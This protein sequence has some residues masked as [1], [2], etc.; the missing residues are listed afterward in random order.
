MQ[1]FFIKGSSAIS[2]VTFV[3][4]F[5]M[6]VVWQGC[7]FRL[8]L[9]QCR[10]CL[11]KARTGTEGPWELN[12]C[13]C[14]AQAMKKCCYHILPVGSVQPALRQLKYSIHF[15]FLI[16]YK[17]FLFSLAVLNFEQLL[18]S[19][20]QVEGLFPRFWLVYLKAHT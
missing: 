5:I 16:F 6:M 12:D 14:S 15:L 13:N 17:Q 18:S 19:E 8:S 7:S 4:S 1:I 11:P 2:C 20:N 3:P 9:C 10:T